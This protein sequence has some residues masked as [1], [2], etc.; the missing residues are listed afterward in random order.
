[1]DAAESFREYMERTGCADAL[2]KVLIEIDKLQDELVSP[3]E[4]IRINLDP[5]LTEKFQSLKDRI[6]E[7]QDEIRQLFEDYPDECGKFL[8]WKK[9]RA[10]KRILKGEILPILKIL[11]TKPIENTEDNNIDDKKLEE[12]NPEMCSDLETTQ[13]LLLEINDSV[14][15]PPES[16]DEEDMVPDISEAKSIVEPIELVKSDEPLNVSAEERQE[17]LFHVEEEDM[18]PSLTI[19]SI[20][21][22]DTGDLKE[23]EVPSNSPNQITSI[24]DIGGPKEQENQLNPPNKNPLINDTPDLKTLE[25]KP[26]PRKSV[27]FTDGINSGDSKQAT[28]NTMNS[29]KSPSNGEFSDDYDRTSS[30]GEEVKGI[31]IRRFFCC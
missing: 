20:L 10:K 6:N 18:Q 5:E 4:Y 3:M 30:A 1:M 23:T 29:Q 25:I 26:H 8:K 28:E 9:K 7:A 16:M 17:E 13:N 31:S 24:V 27:S 15:K 21:I 12:I 22:D 14:E 11:E 2:W 19:D